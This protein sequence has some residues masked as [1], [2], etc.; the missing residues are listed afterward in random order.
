M[1]EIIGL[2]LSTMVCLYLMKRIKLKIKENEIIRIFVRILALL[3]MWCIVLIFQKISADFIPKEK[4]I[5]FDYVV[6]FA[7]CLMPVEFVLLSIEMLGKK[8]SETSTRLLYIV[9]VLSLAI[10]WTND[11]HG[12]FYKVYSVNFSEAV[13]GPFF[14]INSLYT[15]ILLGTFM[16]VSVIATIR[17]SGFVSLPTAIIIGSL[18]FSVII[19]LLGTLRVFDL[20]IYITPL[21]FSVALIG[22][23]IAIFKYKALNIT[24]VALR[25]V[26]DTMSHGYLLMANDGTIIDKNKMFDEMFQFEV[27]TNI[28]E[29][30]NKRDYLDLAELKE[31]IEKSKKENGKTQVKEKMLL[32]NGTKKW[33][34]IEATAIKAKYGIQ[35]IAVLMIFK[36]ITQHKKDIETIKNKQD[37]IVKQ[38]QLVSIGELAGGVAHDINTPISAIK[39]GLGLFEE[40]CKSNSKEFSENEKQLLFRMNNCADKIIKI[41]NSMRNQIRNLGSDVKEDFKVSEILQDVKIIAFNE[42]QKNKCELEI[43]IFDDLMVNGTP[44]KLSQVFTNLI[45]NA[46]QAYE[47][48]E[49]KIQVNV[50]KAPKNKVLIEIIDYAGGIPDTIKESVFK[51]I[52][53]TKGVNGTGLGLYL[54][55]SVIKGEFG[56]EITFE[57]EKGQGTTFYIYLDRIDKKSK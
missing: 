13:Y 30:I 25:T 24:P 42:L 21:T 56:G 38:G 5:Y 45:I 49:G 9:P 19:N 54:A 10:L 39:T 36:D 40:M 57:S 34:E 17:K 43:N 48:K 37:V 32:S 27:E 50:R 7:A 2:I 22:F 20:N 51:N 8:L 6:Y 15:Y 1:F 4:L 44:T 23:Y 16:V 14:L 46:M 12:L 26:I 52:L 41:V 18:S 29:R 47:G 35:Y 55:Y 11:L 3:S 28:F 53:T 33:F 31:A